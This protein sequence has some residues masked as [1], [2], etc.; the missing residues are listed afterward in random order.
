MSQAE[1]TEHP[2]SS[3]W[4]VEHVIGFVTGDP[5]GFL[6]MRGYELFVCRQ[7]LLACA[8]SRLRFVREMGNATSVKGG[9]LISAFANFVGKDDP[10]QTSPAL[11]STEDPLTV[12]YLWGEIDTLAIRRLRLRPMIKIFIKHRNHKQH[13]FIIPNTGWRE[14][15]A[16]SLEKHYG[17]CT[18]EV[19]WWF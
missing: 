14:E 3:S 19:H 18:R 2:A 9:R 4:N 12:Q 15:I 13:T 16:V 5:N 10:R 7:G 1:P 6:K 11:V 8:V 17:A